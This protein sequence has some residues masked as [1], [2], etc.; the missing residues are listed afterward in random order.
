MKQANKFLRAL[1]LFV[2]VTSVNILVCMH[3]YPSRYES[4]A[5]ATT[6][7]KVGNVGNSGSQI[8]Q[9]WLPIF[10]NNVLGISQA[11]KHF[12]DMYP[13]KD[14]LLGGWIDVNKLV[15]ES[16]SDLGNISMRV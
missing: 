1:F 2:V 7:D 4:A 12:F 3:L 8:E 11:M 13:S 16:I 10:P 15:I 9:I 5:V 6:I 14:Q